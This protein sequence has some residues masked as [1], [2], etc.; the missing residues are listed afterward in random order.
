MSEKRIFTDSLNDILSE[1]NKIFIFIGKMTYTEFI[2]D[3]KT[4]YAVTRSLEIIGE[5]TKNIPNDV[6][7]TYNQIPWSKIS[8]MRNKLIH[9][10]FGVDLE[11]LWNTIKN[12][13]PEI[14]PPIEKILK[15]LNTQ[16]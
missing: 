1:I 4:I 7:D 8:G 10:Y 6:K 11:T 3:E 14:K 15:N 13:L 12:R 2:K 9:E 16:K 5:A